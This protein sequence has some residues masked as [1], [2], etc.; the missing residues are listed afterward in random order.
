[1]NYGALPLEELQS[2][3]ITDA[4]AQLW[5]AAH[6]E[7]I[8]RQVQESAEFGMDGYDEE[9]MN[10]GS[11]AFRD[12]MEAEFGESLKAQLQNDKFPSGKLRKLL[13]GIVAWLDG[14]PGG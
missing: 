7:Q 9:L 5:I 4:G 1:M 6:A 2:L 8:M 10:V 11:R 14:G 3:A 13:L 12:R